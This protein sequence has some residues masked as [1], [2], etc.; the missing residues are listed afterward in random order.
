MATQVHASGAA[1]GTS[2]TDAGGAATKSVGAQSRS[3]IGTTRVSE[4]ILKAAIIAKP[5][6]ALMNTEVRVITGD[7]IITVKVGDIT[8]NGTVT[9]FDS[10]KYLEYLAGT[11]PE[12]S[13][14]REHIE[15]VLH[16]WLE[17]NAPEFLKESY[18]LIAGNFTASF[19]AQID[20]Q[21]TTPTA[22]EMT[23]SF[24]V[25][26]EG[27]ATTIIAP[28]LKW[29]PV[30]EPTEIWTTINDDSYPFG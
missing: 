2:A 10:T 6:E 16:P 21:S 19:G 26:V 15:D 28:R 1:V 18:A 3:G 5:E 14:F 7:V 4:L 24:G 25:N 23:A 11:L 17:E 27:D 22:S 12:G 29:E 9:A 30:P 8:R 20:S 13:A